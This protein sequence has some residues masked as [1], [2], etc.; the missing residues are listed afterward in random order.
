MN[1]PHDADQ[2]EVI[3]MAKAPVAGQTKSR[4]A[5]DIGPQAAADWAH[6]TLWRLC[7]RLLGSSRWT[8]HLA[9]TPDGA[10]PD[11]FPPQV[12]RLPQGGGDLGQRMERLLASGMGRTRLI[13]GS[14]LPSLGALEIDSAL[15]LLDATPDRVLLGPAQD[16]GFWLI[17]SKQPLRPGTL[18]GLPWSHAR[19]LAQT[20]ARLGQQGYRVGLHPSTLRD[21]DQAGDLCRPRPGLDLAVL[22]RVVRAQRPAFPPMALEPLA[23]TGLAHDHVRLLGASPQGAPLLLRIPKQS[24]MG[25]PPAQ[26]LAY[27]YA[28]FERAQ[29]SGHTPVVEGALDPG[30]GLPRGALVVR[31][32]A[33]RA[34][35]L[36][37]DL[38]TI[39]TALAGIHRLPL[40][41]ERSRSPLPTS[42]NPLARMHEEIA[43]QSL[44]V[45]RA[46]VAPSDQTSMIDA[47]E[48]V[49][50]VARSAAHQAAPISLITFDA[51]PGNW[52]IDGAG[53]AWIVDLEKMRYSLPGFDLA[54]ATLYTSTTW[55]VAVSADLN[56]DHTLHAY[57]VWGEAMGPQ[58]SVHLQW[59]GIA[60]LAMLLWS[61][62]WCCMWRVTHRGDGAAHRGQDWRAGLS[63]A[64]LVQH[65]RNR[66][67][68]Y[69][70]PG[71]P[72][73]LLEGV[74]A[75]SAKLNARPSGEP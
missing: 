36:P 53:K 65:V 63:E 6:R 56:E 68:H 57:Q 40:P 64:A 60:R 31:E 37:G 17:G 61:L 3:I 66:V 29:Q 12:P 73:H 59:L 21:V 50:A 52:L 22:H 27:E 44:Y 1:P 23:D 62:S 26:A 2:A 74:K 45:A 14:D 19:V 15:D 9:V 5:A 43:E 48:Q 33:G 32:I 58:A 75:F 49:A 72:Q 10:D 7:A 41:P 38:P 67:D 34:P 39:M 54:H 35:H 46:D 24:Q 51:H 55:D 16:G 4:L 20:Q 28:C 11:L 69:L 25:L 71:R 70:S 13:I 42:Q 47:L 8:L 18:S 30:P